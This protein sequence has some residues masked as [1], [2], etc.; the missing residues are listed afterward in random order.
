MSAP[1]PVR[2]HAG[3]ARRSLAHAVQRVTA[4]PLGAYQSAVVR[5]GVSATYLLFLLRELPHRH[6]LY[7]PDGP[8][9]WDMARRLISNNDAFTV[10][11]WSDSPLWFETVYV[12]TL[13]SAALLM[14]GWRTRG[15]SVVFMAGVLS[16]QNRSIFM[17]DGGDNVIHLMALYVVLTRCARVWSLD[18]RRAA[19]DAGRLVDG[20][21]PARDVAGPVLWAVLGC[22][23]LPAS[24]MGGL[25]GTWWLPSLLWVLWLGNGGWWALNRYAPGHELRA[26]L[27]VLANF[28]HNASLLVIMAEVCLIYATAGWYKVQGSRW[29][30]GTAIY[31]PLKLDYFTPW[32]G[33][34]GLLASSALAIM[35]LTYATVIVQVAFPFTLFNRRVKNVLLVLMIGEHAGIS[36]LLGLPFFSMAMVAA[37]AVFLPTAFLVWLGHRVSFCRHRLFDR[38]AGRLRLPR[39]RRAAP[40]DGE[41]THSGSDSGHTLVG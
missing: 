28:A 3:T 10:L 4:S 35:L 23:L 18:A 9:S 26:F 8:W 39:Q 24:L 1:A 36:V 11:M 20:G 6:E 7:G 17:G 29:Q 37:D 13:V 41:P 16:L 5:I 14:V 22:V 32:P 21:G 12:I 31:Y 34:S 25:G 19:R 15:T 33:L 2:A 27:D 30:D 40:D 38:S